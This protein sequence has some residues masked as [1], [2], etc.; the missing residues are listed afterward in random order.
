[1]QVKSVRIGSL[2]CTALLTPLAQAHGVGIHQHGWIDGTTHSFL[3]LMVAAAIGLGLG[4]VLTR[5]NKDKRPDMRQ[6]ADARPLQR[7]F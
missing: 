2:I 6:P 1:M 4:L 3:G 7:R 5:R